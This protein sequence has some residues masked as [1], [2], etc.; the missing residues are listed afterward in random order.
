MTFGETLASLT[1]PR[2]LALLM[3]AIAFGFALIMVRIMR[4]ARSKPDF[5]KE[6]NP[7]SKATTKGQELA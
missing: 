2:I 5:G 7:A 4:H 1:P 6:L 3:P